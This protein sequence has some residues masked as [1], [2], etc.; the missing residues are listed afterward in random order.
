LECVYFVG[1]E[2]LGNVVWGN[3]KRIKKNICVVFELERKFGERKRRGDE[4]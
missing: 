4:G 3:E 2:G 1:V